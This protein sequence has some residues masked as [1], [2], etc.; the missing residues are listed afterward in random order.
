MSVWLLAPGDRSYQ[1]NTMLLTEIGF[2]SESLAPE[3][4][5]KAKLESVEGQI[6]T[7]HFHVLALLQRLLFLSWATPSAAWTTRPRP[8]LSIIVT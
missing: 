6:A 1:D 2:L 3:Y 8:F 7:H 5:L 4:E